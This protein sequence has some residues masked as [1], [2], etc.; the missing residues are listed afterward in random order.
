MLL[1]GAT[2]FD[3]I[4]IVQDLMETDLHRII[5]SKQSLSVDHARYFVYQIIRGL[6]Y[7]HSANVIHRDLKPANLLVKSDCSLKICDF[8]L[9]RVMEEQ[10]EGAYTCFIVFDCNT[11]I[12]LLIHF[13]KCSL[14]VAC[15]ELFLLGSMYVVTRWYRAP[16]ILLNCR[17]YGAAIDVWSVGC[18]MAELLLRK[19]LFPGDSYIDQIKLIHNVLGK[20]NRLRVTIY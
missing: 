15:L 7:L 3:E 18:I 16:E 5:Y 13:D 8:G 19:P 4:Y 9:S 10:D 2:D 12:I 11:N 20:S 14:S 1:V 17:H 6:K